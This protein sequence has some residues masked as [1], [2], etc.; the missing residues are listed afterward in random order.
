MSYRFFK[1]ARFV[2]CVCVIQAACS[3]Q[4]PVRQGQT[5]PLQ[6]RA[7]PAKGSLGV[8]IDENLRRLDAHEVRL[9]LTG[10][11]ISYAL[12]SSADSKI[13]EWFGNDGKWGG[14]RYSR[15]P[16]DFKGHWE[17]TDGRVCVLEEPSPFSKTKGWI[18]REVWQDTRDG[19]LYMTGLGSKG[20]FRLNITPLTR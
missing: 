17:I 7:P 15:G 5:G 20:L 4:A 11:R 19:S 8:N 18:C 3:E 9:T 2:A 13:S 10:Y 14:T 6:S 1:V 16:F 12:P